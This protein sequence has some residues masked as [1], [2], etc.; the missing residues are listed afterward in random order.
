[1]IPDLRGCP[2]VPEAAPLTEAERIEAY[3][4]AR[5]LDGIIA[6]H[7]REAV[8]MTRCRD[9][10]AALLHL[11]KIETRVLLREGRVAAYL[12]IARACNKQGLMEYGGQ[13][14]EIGKLLAEAVRSERGVGPLPLVVHHTHPELAHWT[15]ERG[16]A[17]RPLP[18]SKGAGIEM[19]YVLRPERVRL[20]V[21]RRLFVWGL[22]VT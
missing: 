5:H 10:Y 6:L 13:A 4:A 3:A 7:E 21:R 22:D 20:E 1:L 2:R 15:E 18:C 19:L 8:R 14:A 12:V 16:A 11:P 17:L 9:E